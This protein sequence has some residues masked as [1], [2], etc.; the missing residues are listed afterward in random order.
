MIYLGPYLVVDAVDL[1][2]LLKRHRFEEIAKGVVVPKRFLE[3]FEI[4]L[5]P[6]KPHPVENDIVKQQTQMLENV[7]I[8]FIEDLKKQIPYGY[9]FLWG[10][11][12]TKTP[13]HIIFSLIEEKIDRKIAEL[14]A[15]SKQHLQIFDSL[16]GT[17]DSK[18]EIAYNGFTS[19][20][21][22]I[23][24]LEFMKEDLSE[25][26]ARGQNE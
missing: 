26:L 4:K 1:P 9:S 3:E 20:N 13:E 11:V 14:K 24:H 17:T 25:L 12:R 6:G 2:S 5:P 8:R 19:A 18:R 23:Q 7:S 16:K 10:L 22:N 21:E 15:E